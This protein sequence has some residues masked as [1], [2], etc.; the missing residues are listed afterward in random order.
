MKLVAYY[1]IYNEADF[2][3]QSL[4]SVTPYVDQTII[5]EG[6]WR[7]TYEVNGNLRST[8]G[9]WQ[10]V[11]EY[12]HK[13]PDRNIELHFHNEDSQLEQRNALWKYLKEDC[14][15]LLVDGDEVWPPD[16]IR[17]IKERITDWPGRIGSLICLT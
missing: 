8:D 17:Q 2:I 3:I 14:A 15:M 10:M 13:H 11:Q 16:Q 6:A 5:I 7:E 4:D 12:I 9:T 1:S